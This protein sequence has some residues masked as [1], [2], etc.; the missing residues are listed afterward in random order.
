M[1]GPRKPRVGMMIAASSPT[2]SALTAAEVRLLVNFRKMDS[3]SKELLDSTA[4]AWAE[5][6]PVQAPPPLRL[7]PGGRP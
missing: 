7:I 5:Q 4:K 1:T 6:F 2:A 3:G